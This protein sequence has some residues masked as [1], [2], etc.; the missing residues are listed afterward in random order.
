MAITQTSLTSGSSIVSGTS[1]ATASVTPTANA[2]I[3]ATFTP[4]NGAST[5]P[6]SMSVTGNGLTWVSIGSVNFDNA[7]SSRRTM[8]MFRAL[9]A[10]PSTGVITFTTAETDTGG[11]WTVD[12]FTGVDTSGTNGSGAV[13]QFATNSDPSA[14]VATLTV[15]LAAFGS[16]NNGTYGVF[17]NTDGTSTTTAGSGFSKVSDIGDSNA[18]VSQRQ[19]SEFNSANDTSVDI[20]FSTTA[21]LGGI[22]IEIKASTTVTPVTFI[23]YKPAWR[24]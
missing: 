1:F 17:C 16:V 12:Q 14:T 3:I 10:A 23:T 6:G 15:T 19:T 2:L 9:G 21:E 24:G 20:T 7:S 11:T 4:R 18:A 13:V 8:Q 5:N 22:A